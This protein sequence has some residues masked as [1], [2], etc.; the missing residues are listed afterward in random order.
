[1]ILLLVDSDNEISKKKSSTV[2]EEL[3]EMGSLKLSDLESESAP[4]DIEIIE[5]PE[6]SDIEKKLE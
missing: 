5:K 6:R 4:D 2:T 1:M 3:K